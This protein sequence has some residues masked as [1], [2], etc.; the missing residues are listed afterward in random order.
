M[1]S[2]ES[3]VDTIFSSQPDDDLTHQAKVETLER[4][5]QLYDPSLPEPEAEFA[6]IFQCLAPE[7]AKNYRYS[8]RFRQR[9]NKFF[10]YYPFLL[11]G[12]LWAIVIL[13]LV[14]LALMFSLESKIL[15]LTLWVISIILI[16]AFLIT[17]EYV[18]DHFLRMDKPAVTSQ[19]DAH[20]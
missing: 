7:Y 8:L 2:L 9:K 20:S 19:E 5:Q 18:K 15:F 4:I 12:G 10:H 6:A 3:L 16:S 11:R 13:P 14:F 17:I 1:Q